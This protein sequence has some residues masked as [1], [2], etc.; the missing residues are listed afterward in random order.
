MPKPLGLVL[1]DDVEAEVVDRVVALVSEKLGAGVSLL[2][3]VECRA[4]YDPARGQRRADEV[5]KG[6]LGRFSS[7]NRFCIGLTGE[8]MYVPR[9]NFVFGLA[10]RREG[11]AVVS[12]HR[13]RDGREV[14]VGRLAKEVIHE[15]GHLEGLDHCSN[16]LCVMSFSNTLGE[17]DRKGLDFC[18]VCAKK[19]R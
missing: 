9:L 2:G 4:G 16:E 1:L 7:P 6:C 18:Q 8:D 5:I 12:W 10:L 15:E 11:L 13:L 14:F 17:T 3:R 19:R